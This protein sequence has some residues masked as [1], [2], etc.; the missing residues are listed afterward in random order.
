MTSISSSAPVEQQKVDLTV[1]LRLSDI[2]PLM[3]DKHLTL[4]SAFPEEERGES[5]P[6]D[7]WSERLQHQASKGWDHYKACGDDCTQED[8]D[9]Y[10]TPKALYAVT[11]LPKEVRDAAHKMLFGSPTTSPSYGALV[12][13]KTALFP[14]RGDGDIE[15]LR[16]L[17]RQA[18]RQH[19]EKQR[20]VNQLN[21]L[22][23]VLEE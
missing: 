7:H 18:D 2:Q 23:A 22:L 21:A 11:I 12:A 1:G 6:W 4:N 17:Y 20:R 8:L 19:R 10:W 9:A 5:A 13:I 3:L 14:H 16:D 15:W